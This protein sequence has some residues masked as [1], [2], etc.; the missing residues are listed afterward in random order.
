[1]KVELSLDNGK[2]VEINFSGLSYSVN[3]IIKP[4]IV[5]AVTAFA[6]DKGIGVKDGRST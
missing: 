6:E 5:A 1:M 3:Q 2:N 4:E